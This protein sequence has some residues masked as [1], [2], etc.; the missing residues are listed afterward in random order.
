[1]DQLK[2]QEEEKASGDGKP[3]AEDKADGS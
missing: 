2:Q 1:M 3:K